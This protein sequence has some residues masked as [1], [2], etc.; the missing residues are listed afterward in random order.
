VAV[1]GAQP[2]ARERI[3]GAILAGKI[4]APIAATFPIEQIRDAVTLQAGRHVHGKI[5]V[6]L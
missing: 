6:T 4:T 1:A 3:T 5:V 2:D